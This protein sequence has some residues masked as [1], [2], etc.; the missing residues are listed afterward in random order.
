[1]KDNPIITEEEV[2]QALKRFQERGGLIK[3][4]PDEI[5]PRHTLVGAKY[6]VY[7]TVSNEGT[8]AELGQPAR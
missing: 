1:M 2:Q 8:G 7:E 3:Q 5:V 4:P 6:A